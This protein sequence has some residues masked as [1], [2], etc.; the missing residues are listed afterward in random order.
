ML[1]W[2]TQLAPIRVQLGPNLP[3]LGPNL[4]P[5]WSQLGPTWP[6]LGH[7]L[8]TWPKPDPSWTILPATPL[9]LQDLTPP[10]KKLRTP[11]RPRPPKTPKPPDKKSH[12]R[13]CATNARPHMP[14]PSRSV[15]GGGASPRERLRSG[16][17]EGVQL[18]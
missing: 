18:C 4:A 13:S 15:A 11:K 8:P 3:Q 14:R 9:P 17:P 6:Q 12:T 2:V 16:A 1:A 5:I 10:I 7:N